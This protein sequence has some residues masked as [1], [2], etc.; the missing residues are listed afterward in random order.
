[1]KDNIKN[2]FSFPS[3]SCRYG[4][5]SDFHLFPSVRKVLGGTSV[6]SD[7]DN[8]VISAVEDLC[9]SREIRLQS[10]IQLQHLWVRSSY[11][12]PNTYQSTPVDRSIG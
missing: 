6:A 1:M 4:V 2:P 11:A 3:S 12:S 5:R 7:D 9:E 8:D 10:Q